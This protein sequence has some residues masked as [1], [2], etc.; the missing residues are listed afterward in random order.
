MTEKTKQRAKRRIT[1]EIK[2]AS[3]FSS[4]PELVDVMDEVLLDIEQKVEETPNKPEPGMVVHGN[5]VP[6]SDAELT[7]RY[8]AVEFIP[9]ETILVTYQNIN[10]QLI[11]GVSMAIPQVVYSEYRRKKRE[12][13][14]DVGKSMPR[15][16][17]YIVIENLG[18]GSEL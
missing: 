1:K 2:R 18:V 10:Y 13:L 16:R 14:K 17:G 9:E 7:K 12:A 4:E 5:K 6:W 8:G 3:K 11:T 15:D